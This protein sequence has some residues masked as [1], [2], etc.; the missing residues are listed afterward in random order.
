[1]PFANSLFWRQLDARKFKEV[2]QII[3]DFE[4][5]SDIPNIQTASME[6]AK[7]GAQVGKKDVGEE[8]KEEILT[9]VSTVVS[10]SSEG[11]DEPLPAKGKKRK[12]LGCN[13]DDDVSN[14]I[15]RRKIRVAGAPKMP[16]TG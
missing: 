1:M 13:E 10:H 15:R 9:T 7:R 4:A 14:L 3:M 5:S 2:L 6:E 8:L 11:E 12:S 16:L